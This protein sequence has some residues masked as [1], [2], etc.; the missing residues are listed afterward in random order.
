VEHEHIDVTHAGGGA[1]AAVRGEFDMA[2]TFTVEPALERVLV[3]PGVE[4]LTVDLGA[5]SFIDSTGV[6]VLVRLNDEARERGIELRIAP[7]PPEVQRVFEVAGLAD[8][9]PFA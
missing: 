8:V 1:T 5:V 7:G 4:R 2:A 9:L 3:K 6:G